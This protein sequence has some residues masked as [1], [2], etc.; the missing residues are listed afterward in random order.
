[1]VKQTLLGTILTGCIGLT[2]ISQQYLLDDFV[3]NAS[4]NTYT[5]VGKAADGLESPVDLDFNRL[6]MTELWVINMRTENI[7]GS[8]VTYRAVGTESQTAHKKVDGN[9][10]HFMSL[11]TALAFGENGAWGSTPGVYDANHRGGASAPFTGPSLWS[12]DFNIYAQDAGP[13]TN[14]SHL[15]M[16]HGSPYSMGMAWE[17]DN[18]YWLFDGYNGHIAMYDFAVDH[19]PGNSNH[20]DGR[21]RRYQEV[22]VKRDGLIPSHMELDPARKWLYINDVGNARILRMDITTGTS[23]GNSTVRP[24]EILAE[25]ID[26]RDVVFEVVANTGLVKPCGLDVNNDR[27]IVSDNGTNELI[28]YDITK[29]NGTFPEI[30]RIT[31]PFPDVMGVKLDK[32]GAI[33]FV[34]KTSKEVVRID[35]EAAAVVSVEEVKQ[36]VNLSVYPNPA[37]DFIKFSGNFANDFEVQIFDMSGKQVIQQLVTVESKVSV[38]NLPAGV[39]TIRMEIDGEAPKT[40]RLIKQ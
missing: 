11:P 35:N 30:G 1:M 4:G 24:S 32:K 8:T 10:W 13:G 23:N 27:L 2:G 34:D 39:Y 29:N 26:M 15:D 38:S 14:G 21:I 28:V 9:A 6:D 40:T 3:V 16:L 25:N 33:W 12:S 22:Q 5:V 36:V 31:L 18:K 19:G 20:D 17:Q 7:G 37:N